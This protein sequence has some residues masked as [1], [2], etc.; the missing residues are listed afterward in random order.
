M[1]IN[2]A[3]LGRGSQSGPVVF[4]NTTRFSTFSRLLNLNYCTG[5]DQFTALFYPAND[6]DN[7]SRRFP[8]PPPP[9]SEKFLQLL[10]PAEAGVEAGIFHRSSLCYAG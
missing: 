4:T 5:V 3:A 8:L 1:A 9:P 6:T 2:A 10:R 7:Q